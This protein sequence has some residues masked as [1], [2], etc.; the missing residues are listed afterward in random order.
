MKVFLVR[1]AQ[2]NGNLARR[3]QEDS[4]EL[5]EEGD[6]QAIEITKL[7]CDLNPTHVVSSSL[8]RSLQTACVIGDACD[9]I[10]E[11]CKEFIEL[12]RPKDMYGHYHHSVKS[13][14][15]YMDWYLKGTGGI[16]ED[17]KGESYKALRERVERSQGYLTQFPDD[18][19][20]VVVSHS[21][22]ITFFVAHMCDKEPLNPLKAL[23]YFHKMLTMPNGHI[24]EI[25]YDPNAKEGQCPWSSVDA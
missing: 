24:V 21:V 9:I 3:H 14:K 10:P 13:L 23:A 4:T 19:R 20:V 2:T 7:I 15:Y 22:F 25:D 18:A 5:S 11:T 8:V 16:G 1:H 12:V 17:G 6:K